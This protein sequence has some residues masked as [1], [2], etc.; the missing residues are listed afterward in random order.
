MELG[1]AEQ[2]FEPGSGPISAW[3]VAST[4]SWEWSAL[5]WLSS[6][7]L[8]F[9]LFPQT[10]QPRHNT[11]L[12]PPTPGRPASCLQWRGSPPASWGSAPVWGKQQF[13]CLFSPRR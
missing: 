2:G 12:P 7:T 6:W 4:G 8:G 10:F 3:P 9:Q 11:A 13:V 5:T 1:G